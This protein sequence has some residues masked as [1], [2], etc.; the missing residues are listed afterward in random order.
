MPKLHE[1]LAVEGQLRGQAQATRTELRATFTNKRHLFE[2]KRVTFTPAEDGAQ[3]ISEQ[4]SDLQSK[5]NDELA[6]IA[7]IWSNAIDVS[8]QVADANQRA[9][10]DIVL[11]DGS[12]LLTNVPAVALLELEKRA[13]E[14]HELILAIPTLDPAKGFVI[15]TDRGA[16]V[17]KAREVVKTRTKKAQ[18]PLVLFPATKEHPAQTQIISEDVAVGRVLEQE[19]SGLITPA[20]K[21]IL[22]ERA[23]ALARAVKKARMRANDVEI[24]NADLRTAGDKIFGYVFGVT[25]KQ[26][27][28]AAG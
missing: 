6:W 4:Q 20:E 5:I 22:L 19:W 14:I 2:E 23:E 21:G 18:R 28:H 7:G 24:Q 25:G 10:A 17:Y 13:A 15:D 8:L 1:L 16:G 9:R 11:D 12:T 26:G 3:P 27:K